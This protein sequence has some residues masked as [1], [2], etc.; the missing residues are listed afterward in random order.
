MSQSFSGAQS[1]PHPDTLGNIGLALQAFQKTLEL[2]SSYVLAYQ[3][4]IDALT[5]CTNSNVWVCTADSAVYG[6]PDELTRRLGA[7][8]LQRLRDGARA[9]QV[10]TARGWVAAVPG[11]PRAR[12]AL[13][14]VLY[15]QKR[16][17]DAAA[18]LGAMARL[19][20]AAQAGAWTAVVEFHRGRPGAGAA[21]LDSAL[22]TVADTFSLLIGQQ[23][24][25]IPMVLLAGGGG[26]VKAGF[27]V[28]RSLVGGLPVDS[29]NGPGG[30]LM[31]SAELGRLSEGYILSEAGLP[32][33]GEVEADLRRMLE[34]RARGDSAELRRLVT[35]FG[36]SSL[37]TYLTTRDSAPLVAFLA[38]TD[39]VGSATW[40]V[41]DGLLALERGDTARARMRVD[42]HY[43]QPAEAE[44]TGDQGVI[45]SYAWGDLLARLGDARLALEAYGRIDSAEARIQHPGLVV[46]SWAERGALS[47]RLGEVPQAVAY[48]ERFIEAWKDADA[49]LQPMVVQARN[50]VAAL[51]GEVKETGRR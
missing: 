3:H 8:T 34:R 25:G 15:N 37:A 49:E 10:A 35:S 18:E 29:T 33:A 36:S 5:G 27:G 24:F 1:P 41:A 43:R 42:R 28:L 39:T 2:D 9:K 48:Y 51:R 40:R 32:A 50:A 13:V 4:I 44:F 23:N 7:A 12:M 20:W 16:Y 11:T 38:R 30:L 45:R 26:R 14:Q 21:A 19:G 6:M 31:S 46:R 22:A 47:Q 17:D